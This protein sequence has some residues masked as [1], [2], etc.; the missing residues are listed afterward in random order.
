MIIC[1]LVAIILLHSQS[2]IVTHWSDHWEDDFVFAKYN[3]KWRLNY[4]TCIFTTESIFHQFGVFGPIC[5]SKFEH[6]QHLYPIDRICP[7]P[8]P[9][10]GDSESTVAYYWSTSGRNSEIA[11]RRNAWLQARNQ[12]AR[13][14]PMYTLMDQNTQF[15]LDVLRHTQPVEICKYRSDVVMPLCRLINWVLA[16]N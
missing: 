14:R 5:I 10:S 16:S 15:V 2:N 11:W 3:A 8:G 1:Y 7:I 6:G 9:W 12:V 4:T 13:C